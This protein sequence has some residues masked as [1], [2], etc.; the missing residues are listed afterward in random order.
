MAYICR[1]IEGSLAAIDLYGADPGFGLLN[2]GI[3]LNAPEQIDIWG[4]RLQDQLVRTDEGKRIIPLEMDVRELSDIA[5]IDAVN[6]LQER[7]NHAARYRVDG[8]GDEVFLEFNFGDAPDA[9]RFPVLKG[10]IDATRL[11][12]IFNRGTHGIDR[13]PVEITCEAYWEDDEIFSL[14]NYVDNPAFWRGAVAPGDSWT[15]VDPAGN[16]TLAWAT[17]ADDCVFMGRA[18][19]WTAAHDPVNDIGVQSDNIGVTALEE[20]YFEVRGHQVDAPSVCDNITARVYDVTTGAVIPGSVL[21]MNLPDHEYHKWGTSFQIP[22]GCAIARIEI[23][24]LA[25]DSN[26]GNSFFDCDGIYLGAPGITTPPVGWCSGRNLVNH[27][28]ADADHLNVLCV[29][30]IPGDVEA[31]LKLNAT[32][33]GIQTEWYLARRTRNAPHDFI[34]ELLGLNAVVGTDA[35]LVGGDAT[36][37]G[38]TRVD[39]SFAT[40][41]TMALR[42]HWVINTNLDHYYG[43]FAL[44]VMAKA[45]AAVDTINMETRAYQDLA[46]GGYW[47]Q[48]RTIQQVV[49]VPTAEDWVLMDGWTIYSFP[50][51]THDNDLWDTGNQWVIEVYASIA[52]A[53][54]WDNLKI[55]GAYIVPV[56]ESY[57]IAGRNA[58]PAAAGSIWSIKDMDGDR[59]VLVRNP[60]LN[61]YYSNRGGA[62][63][64]PALIPK[65]ENWFYFILAGRGSST[66]RP[67]ASIT[68]AATVALNYRPRGIFLRGTN[69]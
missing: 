13:V 6:A 48:G 26:P 21:T 36:A 60:A 30:E 67:E 3:R 18:L 10:M 65:H 2:Q 40:V 7:L 62:G 55:A 41:Q 15:E 28:D 68:D 8:W 51:G 53:A 12:E 5:L 46:T 37:P 39:V 22:A 19:G 54:P 50:I 16:L 17:A 64:Y 32:M 57:F 47:D 69:P 29:A 4:G 1:L 43:K 27:L 58:I 66:A 33:G 11:M 42:C 9:V 63:I 61:R 52:G 23:L 14:E 38:G 34:W 20:R 31:E 59:G 44:I 49:P 56:D 24:R 35:V 45:T 25:A